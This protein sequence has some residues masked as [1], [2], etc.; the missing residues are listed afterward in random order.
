M[1]ELRAGLHWVGAMEWNLGH[2]HGHELSIRQGSSYN[3][4]LFLDEKIALMDSVRNTHSPHFMENLSKLVPIDKIDYLIVLHG[5]PDH[6][7]A[8]PLLME[9][10]KNA[11]VICSKNGVTSIKRHYPGDWNLCPQKTG[12]TI[13]LGKRSLRFFEAPMLHWPDSMFA[14]CPEEKI[15]FPNDAFGQHYASSRRYADEVD[16]CQLWFEARKYFANILTPFSSQILKKLAEFMKLEWPIEAIFPSHG[17]LWRKDPMAIAHKYLEWASGKAENNT[18]ILFD[19]IWGGTERMAQAI[20]RGIDSEG[21]RYR[22]YHAG[23]SDFNDVMAEI[24]QSRG[25]VV[26][27]PTLNNGV[28]PTLGP[29]LISLQHLKFQKKLGATF[30]TYGWSGEGVKYLEEIL[31]KGGIKIVQPGLKVQFSPGC[32]DFSECEAFGKNFAKCLKEEE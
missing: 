3:S 16:Q 17:L 2:F 12:D 18:V 23:V 29:S 11:K 4:F 28:M 7:G 14:Y 26:G 13:S 20:G 19:S 5:E 32:P 9:K 1:T 10:A 31:Q 27:S 21:L 6:S 8:L 25:L 15:L 22:I 24:L 30:G